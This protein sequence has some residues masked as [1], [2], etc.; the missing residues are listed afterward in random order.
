M[1]IRTGFVANSSSSSFI[2]F[3]NKKIETIEDAKEYV[4]YTE[5]AE[6]FLEEVYGPIDLDNK[7]KAMSIM[8]EKVP[9]TFPVRRSYAVKD[10]EII[11]GIKKYNA[12]GD[13]FD[14]TYEDM[15]RG[16]NDLLK[17]IVESTKEKY[18]YIIDIDDDTEKEVDMIEKLRNKYDH[19]IFEILNH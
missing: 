5:L 18:C 15:G 1:K 7:T 6:K 12:L 19:I 17:L 8:T 10:P 13:N 14:I 11:R 2:I 4:T 9:A 3:T 16:M